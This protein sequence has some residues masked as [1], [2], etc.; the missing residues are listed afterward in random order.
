VASGDDDA[1]IRERV[2]DHELAVGDREAGRVERLFPH[3]HRISY[4]LGRDHPVVDERLVVR[5]GGAVS[6]SDGIA[7]DRDRE[8]L[9]RLGDSDGAADE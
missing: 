9:C 3:A 8:V 5:Q 6:I 2:D 4:P 1:A 7:L